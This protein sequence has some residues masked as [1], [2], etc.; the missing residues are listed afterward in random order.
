MKN[1]PNNA[2]VL[3]FFTL[4]LMTSCDNGKK[5]QHQDQGAIEST[6]SSEDR[7]KTKNFDTVISE[8]KVSL[9]WLENDSMR[10]AIT[11]YGGRIVGLWVPD[12]NGKMIDVVVGMNSILGYINSTE[13]YFGATIGRVG[14]RIADGKFNLNGKD[15]QVPINNGE[16]ALHG[17]TEGFQSKIWKIDQ[18]ASQT[19]K[20]SYQS[21]DME[22]GFP[23]NLKVSISYSINDK[24]ELI[25][26]YEA[27]TDQ[28]TPVNL[29]NHAFFNLNGEGSSTILNHSLK[30]FADSFTPVDE[31]LIPTG[32]IRNVENTPFD[33]RKSTP[34][35]ERIDNENEQL[36]FGKGYDHNYI[37]NK[38]KVNELNHAAEVVGDKSG[39]VM[40][41]YTEEPS[42]QFYS[43]NFMK[44]L[45][46]F[47]SGKTDIFRTAFCLETQHFPDSPNQETFPTIILEPGVR[48]HT[49]SIYSFSIK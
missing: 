1:L 40:N 8:R 10:V 22:Q 30:I 33:F 13:A 12:Q 2:I 36:S 31:G 26:K 17:G 34:I 6:N 37:L 28:S 16:N 15:Y 44:G 11:N 48:Y 7:L 45:N 20:L 35:G 46:T 25:L 29:T 38:T 49:K 3:T 5:N 4:L 23:G 14:N 42:L 18:P 47:K 32:E 9:F 27:A 24:K 19:L 21:K 43:G 41:I 39:I